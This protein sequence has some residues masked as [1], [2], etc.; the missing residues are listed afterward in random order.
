MA[1]ACLEKLK[2]WDAFASAVGTDWNISHKYHL[3]RAELAAVG[4]DTEEAAAA[5]VCAIQ[6]AKEHCYINE[7][8]LARERSGLFHL[9]IQGN[10]QKGREDLMIA[11]ELYRKWGA[12]AKVVDVAQL[13]NEF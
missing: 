2:N 6:K 10:S 11:V 8:A 5:Y 7:E 3:L 9:N 13:L 1:R 4:G 12:N